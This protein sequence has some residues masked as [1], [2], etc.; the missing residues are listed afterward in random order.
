MEKRHSGEKE[1]SSCT[2]MTMAQTQRSTISLYPFQPCSR[3]FTFYTLLSRFMDFC[4][5]GTGFRAEAR[6]NH[7][8]C[9][10]LE[11]VIG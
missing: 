9:T 5:T 8:P 2:L 3:S 6:N 1:L 4:T 7:I 11:R 10:S